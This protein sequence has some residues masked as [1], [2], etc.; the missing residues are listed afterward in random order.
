MSQTNIVTEDF[1]IRDSQALGAL[2]R[3]NSGVSGVS[4]ALNGVRAI[5]GGVGQA[6]GFAG[7]MGVAHA[8]TGVTDLYQSI[9]R[10]RAVT[11]VAAA[12]L[13]G[14]K[15]AFELTGGEEV[16]DQTIVRMAR[17]SQ[18][19]RTGSKDAQTLASHLRQVGVDMS[20][21]VTESFLSMSKAVK[22][23]RLGIHQIAK[24]FRIPLSQGADL[25]KTLRTGPAELRKIMDETK[26]SGDLVDDAALESFEAMQAGKR[27][28]KDAWEGLVGTLYKKLIPG[29]TSLITVLNNGLNAA[30]PVAE[31][32]GRFLADHMK[33]IVASAKLYLA[34]M[35]AAKVVSMTGG[36]NLGDAIGGRLKGI[37]SFGKGGAPRMGGSSPMGGLNFVGAG[38]VAKL[39]V[40]RDI[41]AGFGRGGSGTAKGIANALG[42]L[43][44]ILGRIAAARVSFSAMGS[45]LGR[46]GVAGLGIAIAVKGFQVLRA[47]IGGHR[48]RISGVL[49]DISAKFSGFAK[50][51]GPALSQLSKFFDTYLTGLVRYWLT[52]FE[53]WLKAVNGV[54]SVIKAIAYILHD[55]VTSPLWAMRHPVR[56]FESAWERANAKDADVALAHGHRK[57]PGST[58]DGVYQDFR[59][60][61]FNITQAFAEGFDPGRVSV[62]FTER[63]AQ[64]GERRVQAGFAP[65]Q[66]IRG[67]R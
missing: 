9:S 19:M 53:Y 27:Q 17:L 26:R 23:G 16:A 2:G 18:R 12:D 67:L 51:I 28:L 38:D 55:L 10:L 43:S 36:G 60:S 29:A 37:L 54:L 44:P 32:I 24:D 34:Y 22:D 6:A 42:D 30:A 15:D 50:V 61:Q 4:R 20:H 65:V 8:V 31:H 21:G 25:M 52:I 39:L 45:M 13:H 59:G 47:D 40:R 48:T 57:A 11:G 33:G 49:S 7:M 35:T 58:P 66:A 56:L 46:L 5:F 41:G 14:L 1:V 62:A 63:I 3:I 64:I